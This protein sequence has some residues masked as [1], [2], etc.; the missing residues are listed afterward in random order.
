MSI[1]QLSAP[2]WATPWRQNLID[3]YGTPEQNPQF[4]N[5]ISANSYVKDISGP[6]QLHHAKDDSHVPFNFSEK[7]NSQ[8]QE[9][10]K[11]VEFYPYENDDHNLTNSFGT[12]MDRS[13][14][15]F[16]RYLKIKDY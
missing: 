13:V 5:S 15:F 7:L 1:V 6:I 10:D 4:W 14:E 3:Q 2:H 11:L 9:A 16:D 8:L 12:A